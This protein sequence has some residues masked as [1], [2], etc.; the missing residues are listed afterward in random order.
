MAWILNDLG[1][2]A[3]T[4]KALSSPEAASVRDLD[5]FKNELEHAWPWPAHPRIIA[6]VNDI[7]APYGQKGIVGEMTPKEALDGAAAD[8]QKLLDER[9]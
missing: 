2:V 4:T 5:L 1:A 6:I 3:T 8:A 9:P 7:L